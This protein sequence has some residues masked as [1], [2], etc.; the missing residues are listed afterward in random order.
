MNLTKICISM[1]LLGGAV[2]AQVVNK[3][4]GSSPFTSDT[5]YVGGDISQSDPTQDVIVTLQDHSGAAQGK[6][7]FMD[8]LTGNPIYC[9][10][11]DSV[12]S[13]PSP[14]TKDITAAVHSVPAGTPLYF[15][16]VVIWGWPSD[17]KYSGA[18]IPG[19]SK[20]VSSASSD[21]LADVTKHYDRRWC[22]M[23]RHKTAGVTDGLVEFGFEDN[24][25]VSGGWG[26]TD[27]D[28]NDAIFNVSGLQVGVSTRTLANKGTVR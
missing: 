5:L 20:Y 2:C 3:F 8:P 1:A 22:V 6:L 17:A 19:V 15:K 18:N 27:M 26:P 24:S 28:F 21:G 4:A 12:T 14:V 13:P 11:N 16:F 10:Q 9:F 23:G 7:Y 25:A